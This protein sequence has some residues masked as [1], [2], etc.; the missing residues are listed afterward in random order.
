[1]R[2]RRSR[3]PGDQHRSGSALIGAKRP[4]RLER[5]GGVTDEEKDVARA[6]LVRDHLANERTYLAWL[7]TTA[8]VIMLGL[9]IANFVESGSVRSLAA[10]SLLMAA[11]AVGAIYAALKYRT[12]AADINA[13]RAESVGRTAGPIAAGAVLIVV[14]MVAL[15]LLLLV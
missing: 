3:E 11:G 4:G 15:L 7:R 13:G 9:A 10:G 1:M 5:S 12:T 8:G 14:I 2:D 6:T